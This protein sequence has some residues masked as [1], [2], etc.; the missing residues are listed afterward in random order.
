MATEMS[1]VSK[2][3]FQPSAHVEL[4]QKNGSRTITQKNASAWP[5][6]SWT[7]CLYSSSTQQKWEKYWVKEK[8]ECKLKKKQK[9]HNC[10]EIILWNSVPC[11]WHHFWTQLQEHCSYCQLQHPITVQVR[12][13]ITVKGQIWALLKFLSFKHLQSRRFRHKT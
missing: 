1:C 8:L 13:N 4:Q 2:G 7:G 10:R 11:N 5:F 3:R 9:P 12:L 6:L